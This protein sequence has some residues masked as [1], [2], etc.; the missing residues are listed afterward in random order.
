MIWR[1]LFFCYFASILFFLM[2]WNIF[3]VL[4]GSIKSLICHFEFIT[5]WVIFQFLWS[6]LSCWGTALLILQHVVTWKQRIK[7]SKLQHSC[8]YLGLVP[9]FRPN[10]FLRDVHGQCV[11]VRYKSVASVSVFFAAWSGKQVI[12]LL[13]SQS[14]NWYWALAVMYSP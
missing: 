2:N 8:C 14:S 3:S 6:D 9:I 4:Q 11:A 7:L 1:T 10:E 5:P 13:V 12:K